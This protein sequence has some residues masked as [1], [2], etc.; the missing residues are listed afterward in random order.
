MATGEPDVSPTFS[1]D[2]GDALHNVGLSAEFPAGA[3]RLGLTGGAV[4]CGACEALILPGGDWT[5]PLVRRAA[6]DGTFVVG[7]NTAF[8]A[9]LPTSDDGGG[10]LLSGSLGLPLSMIAG[11]RDGLRAVPFVMPAIGVGAAIGDDSASGVRP[12][13]GGGIGVIAASGFGVTAGFQKVFIEDGEAIIG[14][15]FTVGGAS[16]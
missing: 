14:L 15:A 4:V 2:D 9:G 10:V 12:M 13:L 6:G 8:G 1:F 7:L 5:M 16:R 3:G 11:S